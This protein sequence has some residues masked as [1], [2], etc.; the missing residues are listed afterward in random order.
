M[1]SHREVSSTLTEDGHS[2][3][4]SPEGLDVLLDKPHRLLLVAQSVVAAH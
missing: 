2:I 1:D 4:P 3:R